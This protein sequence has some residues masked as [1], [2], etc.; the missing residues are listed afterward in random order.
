MIRLFVVGCSRSGT[1]IVQRLLAGHKDLISFPET[2]FFQRLAGD[3]ELRMF[4]PEQA[5]KRTGIGARKT[6]CPS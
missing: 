3:S 2:A 5:R 1:T 4:G 6:Q